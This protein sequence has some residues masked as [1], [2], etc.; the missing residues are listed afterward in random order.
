MTTFLTSL[1]GRITLA[2]T[3]ILVVVLAV[4]AVLIVRLVDRQLRNDLAAQNDETLT[5]IANRINAGEDPA[6]IRLPL[7]TDGTEFIVIGPGGD[8]VNS[9]IVFGGAEA[10]LVRAGSEDGLLGGTILEET[11]FDIEFDEFSSESRTANT[12]DGAEFLV[13]AL[14]PN[15]I[16]D[17]SVAQV[18]SVLWV[19]IPSLALVFSLLVWILTGR[20]LRPVDLLTSKA[21]HIGTGTLHERLEEPGTKDEIDRLAKTL[22]SMLDRLDRGAKAQQQ[23]VS[24]ASHELQS[25]LTVVLGEAQ[26]AAADPTYERLV[27]A[28][29]IVI[30]HCERMTALIRDL[31]DLARADETEMRRS[32]IDVDDLVRTEARL[33]PAIVDTRLVKPARMIGHAGSISRLARNLIDNA[34]RYGGSTIEVACTLDPEHGWIELIVDDDGPGIPPEHRNLVF[35]RFGR[36]DAARH[37]NTGGTGLGL[38]MAKA[39]VEAHDGSITVADAPIGGARFI[40]NLPARPFTGSRPAT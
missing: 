16:V 21:Q 11:I 29:T 23:F 39:I 9:T 2:S 36:V 34:S 8:S 19:V 10:P 17:R 32:E 7:A 37:R 18:T 33:H 22:N 12:P 35:E 5:D 1:R 4:S 24:D 13:Q 3:G 26:L 14:N 30:E 6:R 38:A 15:S 28:N 40:I 27:A 20:L 31:L 25:P